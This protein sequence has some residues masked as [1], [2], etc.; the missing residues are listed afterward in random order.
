[1]KAEHRKELETN[2]LADKVGKLISG[3]R[4]GPS[5][6]FL[7]Y[8][9][10]GLAAL[11]VGFLI[12]RW[13]VS[14]RSNNSEN[15]TL[16]EFGGFKEIEAVLSRA[17]K[18]NPGKAARCQY[19]YHLLWHE[20]LKHLGVNPRKAREKIDDAEKWYQEIADECK[21]D[22]VFLPEAL[23]GLAIIEETRL[24]EKKQRETLIVV[25]DKYKAV[26]KANKDSAFAALARKRVEELEDET[27]SRDILR[28]Y[29]DLEAN[30]RRV[31]MPFLPEGMDRDEFM[32]KFGGKLFGP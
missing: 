3:A 24:L 27:K 16:L 22:P 12:Y 1:M 32:K 11:V 4:E 8:I 5:R 13:F 18:E 9:V 19:A 29:Q 10:C 6:G 20:G 23:Y 2:I 26:D 15:W 7:F 17:G 25:I 14:G 28:F 21:G 31:E 30:L